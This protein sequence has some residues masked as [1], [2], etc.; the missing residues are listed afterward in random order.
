MAPQSINL[1]NYSERYSAKKIILE[2]YS[3]DLIL[4]L[5]QASIPLPEDLAYLA[6][7][8]DFASHNLGTRNIF[9]KY[10]NEGLST[11]H[12]GNM[13]LFDRIKD[14]NLPYKKKNSDWFVP[15]TKINNDD[16]GFLIEGLEEIL[17]KSGR[18]VAGLVDALH[19]PL[20]ETADNIYYHSGKTE[21]S[22]WGFAC[23]HI[24]GTNLSVAF[25]DIGV[26][27]RG[28]LER[29]GQE[30]SLSDSEIILNAF[31]EGVTTTTN[32]YRGIGL[33]EVWKYIMQTNG[34][35]E[36]RSSTG[37]ANIRKGRQNVME[38]SW[39]VN[40]VLIT[41]NIPI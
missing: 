13:G 37:V 28:A 33:A 18:P 22:G 17:K 39:N 14:Y 40:G 11:M 36:V 29:S 15:L 27:F 9:V 26:G 41:L 34:S 7:I 16:N 25:A 35:I 21:N 20:T 38:G 6:C 30:N 24:I 4:D 10:P 31:K 32:P 3:S 19:T 23:G 12:A 8:F 1:F 2:N 5:S